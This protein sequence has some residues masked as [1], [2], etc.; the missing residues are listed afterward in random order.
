[1]SKNLLL[2]ALTKTLPTISGLPL[3]FGLNAS[4]SSKCDHT[5]K[6]DLLNLLHHKGNVDVH[7]GFLSFPEFAKILS[8]NLLKVGL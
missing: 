3:Q 2:A 6:I 4:L 1:M 7:V 5:S 8:D